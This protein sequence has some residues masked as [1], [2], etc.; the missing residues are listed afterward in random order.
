[1]PAA[2]QYYANGRGA[3]GNPKTIVMIIQTLATPTDKIKVN[4]M[5]ISSDD[6]P[7][8]NAIEWKVGHTT[9]AGTGGT[10]SAAGVKA[11]VGEAASTAQYKSSSTA[12]TAEPTYVD[13]FFDQGIN[14]R[15]SYV[16]EL[17]DGRE[18]TGDLTQNHGISAQATHASATVRASC[19]LVWFE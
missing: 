3:I 14:Q 17:A 19:T 4:G 15:A 1:M 11:D 10:A 12:W 16:L 7:A 5:F 13:V 2:A 8:D 6:T 18:W 9:T